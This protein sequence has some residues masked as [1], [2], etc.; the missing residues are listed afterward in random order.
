MKFLFVGLGNIGIEYNNTRH[1]IGFDVV[2]ELAQ[3]KE[4]KFESAKH[5]SIAEGKYAGKSF[6]LLKPSTYMNLSGRAVNYWLQELEVPLKNLM[7]VVDDLVLPL[8]KIR[9]RGKGSSAGH[10]GLKSIEEVFGH[11]K[12][13]RLRIGIGDDFRPGK[14]ID[15]VLG[16][17]T[18]KEITEVEISKKF[19]SESLLYF[20]RHGL[21]PTMTE[22]NQK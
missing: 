10:N 21:S 18:E 6:Y 15:F 1:N 19:A 3:L 4:L 22:Y 12:Y 20:M 14:Q 7:I 5:G 9:V 11:N 16:K 2:D 17:W 13:N 8:G